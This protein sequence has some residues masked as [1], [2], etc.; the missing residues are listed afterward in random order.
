MIL[1]RPCE[2]CSRE[3]RQLDDIVICANCE[4]AAVPGEC[5]YTDSNK[6]EFPEFPECDHYGGCPVWNKNEEGAAE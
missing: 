1:E 2:V 4:R 5:D 3:L 6:C